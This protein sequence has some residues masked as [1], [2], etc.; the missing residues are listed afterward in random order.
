MEL[1][2]CP[3]LTVDQA[4]AELTQTSN[5]AVKAD[6][7][8]YLASRALPSHVIAKRSKLP[9]YEIRKLVRIGKNLNTAVKQLLH[10]EHITLGHARVIAGIPTKEQESV[11]RKVIAQR[12]SVRALE[13]YKRGTSKRLDDETAKYY[14]R[15]SQ[16]ASETIGHPL[17]ITPAAKNKNAGVIT[18]KYND[19]DSFDS[20]F[21]RL[22][23]VLDNY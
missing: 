12:I 1:P 4:L 2:Y 16:T 14:Q 9:G 20:I 23:I 15:L 7:T 19:L 22:Q 10:Q 21:D 11:A 8:A 5:P 17:S 6:I 13:D 18:I 3:A